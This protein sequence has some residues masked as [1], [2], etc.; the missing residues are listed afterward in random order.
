[1]RKRYQ[2]PGWTKNSRFPAL[3][4]FNVTSFEWSVWRFAERRARERRGAD[5][6]CDG[7]P[8]DKGPCP[9]TRL[10]GDRQHRHNQREHRAGRDQ[11]RSEPDNLTKRTIP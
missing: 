8:P 9:A 7:Q 1:M 5:H 6:V 3:H 4:G 2:M 10:S 11:L